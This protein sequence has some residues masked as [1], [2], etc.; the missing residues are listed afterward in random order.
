MLALRGVPTGLPNGGGDH[1]IPPYH[2]GRL[3]HSLISIREVLAILLLVPERLRWL[4]APYGHV[5]L[6][7]F[8]DLRFGLWQ[9]K[10]FHNTGE[11]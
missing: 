11:R 8:T 6:S 10:S 1:R 5:I 9:M 2:A 7:W 3:N 4:K